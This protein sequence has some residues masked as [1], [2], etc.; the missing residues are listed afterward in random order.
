MLQMMTGMEG[1]LR[2]NGTGSLAQVESLNCQARSRSCRKSEFL[3]VVK[4]PV[5]FRLTAADFFSALK[6]FML[7]T[8]CADMEEANNAKTAKEINFLIH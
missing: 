4:V 1:V 7:A 5:N 6:S 3:V 8:V 2:E